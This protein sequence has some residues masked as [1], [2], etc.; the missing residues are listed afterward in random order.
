[1]RAV[2]VCAVAVACEFGR[3]RPTTPILGDVNVTS[4]PAGALIL[5]NGRSTGEVTPAIVPAPADSPEIRLQLQASATEFFG[6]LGRV[7]VPETMQV[8]VD[9]ALVGGCAANCPF[10]VR[11]TRTEC[12]VVGFGDFCSTVFNASL[13]GTNEWPRDSGNEYVANLRVQVAAIVGA[14]GDTL[15]GDTLVSLVYQDT[16]IGRSPIMAGADQASFRYW[17][18]PISALGPQRLV[19]LEVEQQVIAPTNA[20]L[21]D[22]LYFRF[23]LRNVT[24]DPRHRHWRPEIPVGGFTFENLYAG[25]ALDADIGAFA[26]DVGTLLADSFAFIYDLD[27][28]D[29]EL[30]SGYST[31]PPLVGLVLAETPPGVQR[32]P[33]S[34]WTSDTD[35]DDPAP[36]G[37][38]PEPGFGY[39]VLTAQLSP[40]DPLADCTGPGDDIGHCSDAIA[41]YRLSLTAGPLTLAPGDTAVFAAALVYAEPA[42]GQFTPGSPIFPG[43][44]TTSRPAL[45]A[46]ADSLLTRARRA[47]ALWPSVAP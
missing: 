9:A 47:V 41:D 38:G 26:D 15:A 33:F 8:D 43:D 39:R 29:P 19:G 40:T 17:A 18:D 42:P 34:L 7:A 36:A 4:D 1:M 30:V 6:W 14:D 46:V 45:E 20:D 31:M 13:P 2:V 21:R 12:L 37:G 32:R 24:D 44:P 10:Q 35:W 25:M 27:F 28:Q 5:V 16:W 23:R 22:V 11:T 3:D